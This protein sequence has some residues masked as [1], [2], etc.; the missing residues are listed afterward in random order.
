[1]K[2]KIQKWL[3]NLLYQVVRLRR[4]SKHGDSVVKFKG[5]FSIPLADQ[6]FEFNSVAFKEIRSYAKEAGISLDE[7]HICFFTKEV[8]HDDPKSHKCNSD[9]HFEIFKLSEKYIAIL[10]LADSIEY[11]KESIGDR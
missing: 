5:M 4:I 1:M 7:I 11:G 9:I 6:A 8:R 3:K 10:Y 2:I